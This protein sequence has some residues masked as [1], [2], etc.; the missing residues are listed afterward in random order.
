M[1]NKAFKGRPG[2]KET[3]ARRGARETVASRENKRSQARRARKGTLEAR[4]VFKGPQVYRD[5]WVI[6]APQATLGLRDHRAFRV[7]EAPWAQPACAAS[8]A[9]G[10]K[11]V[12]TDPRAKGA[13]R[14]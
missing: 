12:P 1:E 11:P 4:K 3:R 5:G 7:K 8:Q 6:L 10:V 14:A 13:T 2:S 9:P